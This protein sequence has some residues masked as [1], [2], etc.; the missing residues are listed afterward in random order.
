MQKRLKIRAETSENGRGGQGGQTHLTGSKS[1][2]SSVSDD[3][4]TS[5]IKK[6]LCTHRK[7]ADRSLGHTRLVIDVIVMGVVV[8]V[9]V[10]VDV[11]HSG[12]RGRLQEC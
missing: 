12:R 5:A 6:E 2:H 8:V 9:V 4:D 10:D 3:G 11:G 7:H 1:K